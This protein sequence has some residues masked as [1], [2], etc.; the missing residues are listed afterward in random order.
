MISPSKEP[1]SVAASDLTFDNTEIAFRS[2]SN[3]ELN[4]AYWLFKIISSNF[5]T[6]VGPPVTNFALNIGLPITSLIKKTIFEHF[7]GGETIEGCEKTIQQLASQ[8]VGT[9]LDYSV[10][11]E[12]SE[13]A[14]DHVLAETIR[15]IERAKK[16][17]NIPF[18]VFKVTGLGRFDLLAKVNAGEPLTE[19]EAAEFARVKNRVEKICAFAH[20]AG[21][22]VLVDAEH[23]WIQDTIDDLA[24][25]MMRKYNTEKAIVYNTYQLY[26]HDIL[27]ALKADVYLAQTDN[28]YVGAKLVRGAYM[29]IERKRAEERGYPSPIQPNKEAADRD[30]NEAIH[31]CLDN[32]DRIGFMAG[33]HNEASSYLLATE[34]DKRGIARGDRRVYFAQ[35]LGMSDNLSF[36]LSAAGYNVAKYMPYGPVKAVMPYLFR[37]A[38]ENTSVAGQTGRELS[39]IIKEKNRRKK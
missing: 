6:K 18:S 29:E 9:I 15:T 37:R 19:T 16:D 36:N 7:C 30:Y 28:F 25:D 3:A 35:L 32:L 8:H 5:L 33:T 2:K 38:Q 34:L 17:T 22:A 23:S 31:F 21:V 26:R 24:R 14:F 27:A 1:Q 10:E 13:Q 20:Q 12:E 39:L 4:R 11:G